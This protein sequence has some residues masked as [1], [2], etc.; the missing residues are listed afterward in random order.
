LRNATALDLLLVLHY[1]AEG[2]AGGVVDADMD[3]L[4]TDPA[5]VALTS[6]VTR[7]AMADPIEFTQLFDVDVD[8]FAGAFAL[9]AAHGLG[10]FQCRQPV[11]TQP[12]QNAAD[13]CRRHTGL[14]GDLLAGVALPTQCLDSRACG[15]R[16]LAWQ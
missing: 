9:I 7:D 11:E 16:R 6:P 2:D 14:G 5:R 15:G 10:Q 1:P 13:G 12:P 4:P 3:E 8:Q